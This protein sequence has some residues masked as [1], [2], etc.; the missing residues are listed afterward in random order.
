MDHGQIWTRI[1]ALA[2]WHEKYSTAH[3]YKVETQNG[4][5]K[6]EQVC[7]M[8]MSSETMSPKCSSKSLCFW[9]YAH[10]ALSGPT[11]PRCYANKVSCTSAV[12]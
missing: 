10:R 1:E 6:T 4:T 7:V 2:K 12:C 3:T 8:D 5:I 9:C 11:A